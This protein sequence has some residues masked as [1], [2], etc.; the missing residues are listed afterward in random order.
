MSASTRITGSRN[1]LIILMFHGLFR[2]EDEAFAGY[3]DPYQPLTEP[4][5]V[6]LIEYFQKTG[7]QFI[8]PDDLLADEFEP[9]ALRVMLTFDDGYANNL[10]ALPI[11]KRFNVPATFFIATGNVASG[12]AFWWDVLFRERVR[13]QTSLAEIVA[14]RQ[15]LKSLDNQGI[16]AH[17]R[18]LFGD[19]AFAPRSDIDRPM[20]I[21][22]LQAMAREPLVTLGNHT[23]DHELLNRVPVAAARRQIAGCQQM[24]AEW[25]G[26]SPN[27][28]AYPNGICNAAIKAEAEQ[29]GLSLGLVSLRGKTSL[30]VKAEERMTLPRYALAGGESLERD[31]RVIMAPFSLSG[32]RQE[33]HSRLQLRA[34]P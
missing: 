15:Q 23:V 32:M 12:E 1:S 18:E 8:S 31:C 20:T 11:L 24:L 5:L 4:D 29:T 34:L 13:R 2:D 9:G 14:E 25:T 22:E 7:Y 3:I 17:L 10:R 33:Y 27:I 26:Q 19:D 30:P 16:K 6:R 28:I 21:A